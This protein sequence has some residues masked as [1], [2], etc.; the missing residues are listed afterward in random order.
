MKPVKRIEIV[1]DAP[2]SRHI[3]ELLTKHGL[4]GWS[5]VRNVTG[6]GERGEQRGDEVTG[7]SSNHLILTTCPPDRI[8][9]LLEEL[10]TILTRIG[11]ICMVSDA[12]W[13]I[14]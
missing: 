11:G 6:S 3:T 8:E 7:V 1:I 14:H 5:I 4:K 9:S 13:L 10:R 12:H 2:H